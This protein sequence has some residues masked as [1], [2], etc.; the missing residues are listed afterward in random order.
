YEALSVQQDNLPKPEWVFHGKNPVIVELLMGSDVH[1]S[2]DFSTALKE[3]DPRTGRERSFATLHV[4]MNRLAEYYYLSALFKKYLLLM[5]M[6]F[7]AGFLITAVILFAFWLRARAIQ[8]EWKNTLSHLWENEIIKT[9]VA[10][11]FEKLDG[12]LGEIEKKLNQPQALP[13]A[14]P[15]TEILDAILIEQAK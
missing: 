9:E 5:A 14:R 8:R 3:K 10:H 12:K 13:H 15:Q 2:T 7:L 4:I 11:G 1:Y 6:V